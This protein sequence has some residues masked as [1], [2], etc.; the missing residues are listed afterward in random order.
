[1][2]N[3]LCSSV[4]SDVEESACEQS[5]LL[6]SGIEDVTFTSKILLNRFFEDQ[7]VAP[8]NLKRRLFHNSSLINI[9]L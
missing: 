8:H 9:A 3:R 6:A 1:M 2:R 7:E 4:I 5:S